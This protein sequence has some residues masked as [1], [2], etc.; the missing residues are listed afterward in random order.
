MVNQVRPA[1]RRAVRMLGYAAHTRRGTMMTPGTAR[2]QIPRLCATVDP[3]R[4]VAGLVVV[5]WSEA[6]T[7]GGDLR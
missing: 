6:F 3:L 1:P 5:A 2:G 4:P 7:S